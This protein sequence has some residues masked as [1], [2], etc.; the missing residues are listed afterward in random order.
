MHL[1]LQNL[2]TTQGW[3]TAPNASAAAV[4]STVQCENCAQLQ[5]V[6]RRSSHKDLV[7]SVALTPDFVISGSYDHTVKVC[8]SASVIPYI[9]ECLMLRA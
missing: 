2:T 7:R 8:H 9:S 5:T 6:A 3:S 4:P 1:R